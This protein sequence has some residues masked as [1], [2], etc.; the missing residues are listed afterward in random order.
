[1]VAFPEDTLRWNLRCYLDW[2]WH[3][4]V[5]VSLNG[6][7]EL[8]G[9]PTSHCVLDWVTAESGGRRVSRSWRTSIKKELCQLRAEGP[10]SLWEFGQSRDAGLW[11][12]ASCPP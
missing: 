2:F 9:L 8:P 12:E 6:V 10:A 11:H 1:M 7:S 3:A 4:G 5:C